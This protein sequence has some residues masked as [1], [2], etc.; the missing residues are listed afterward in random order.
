MGHINE[1]YKIDNVRISKRISFF[2]SVPTPPSTLDSSWSV[3]AKKRS[4]QWGRF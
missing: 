3:S 2:S 4:M 1:K